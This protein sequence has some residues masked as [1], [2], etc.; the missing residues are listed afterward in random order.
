MERRD[1]N[2]NLQGWPK[3]GRAFAVIGSGVLA[4][5][6]KVYATHSHPWKALREV[7]SRRERCFLPS[8]CRLSTGSGVLTLVSDEVEGTRTLDH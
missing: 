2:V 6:V 3:N 4:D 7:P 1:V 5:K 8:V